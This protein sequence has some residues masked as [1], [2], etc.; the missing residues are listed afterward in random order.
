MELQI[1]DRTSKETVKGEVVFHEQVEEQPAIKSVT[2][3]VVQSKAEAR[4][5]AAKLIVNFLGSRKLGQGT[6]ALRCTNQPQQ[7]C[8][9]STAKYPQRLLQDMCTLVPKRYFPNT[10]GRGHPCPWSRRMI[11]RA[12]AEYAYY[13][14]PKL[15]GELVD[16]Q[17][18]TSVPI[19]IVSQDN[20]DQE[21]AQ[22]GAAAQA[23]AITNKFKGK[24][25][26][27]CL[28]PNAE[29]SVSMVFAGIETGS[30]WGYAALPPR[31]PALQYTLKVAPQ[32]ANAAALGIML[33]SYNF[34]RYKIPNTSD[35]K[36]PEPKAK[37]V[38]PLGADRMAVTTLASAFTW[39]R[40]LITTPAEDMGPGHLAAEAAAMA[41]AHGAICRVIEG[42]ELLVQKYPAIHTVGRASTRP[43][44]LI[45]IRWHPKDVANVEALPK[46][47]L[48]GKGVCFDT[49]G[50][51]IKSTAGMRN[52]KKDMGGGAIVL[53]L[54][55]VI[56][57][58]QLPVRLRVMVPAVENNIS[59]NSYRPLDVLKTRAGITV[60]VGTSSGTGNVGMITCLHAYRMMIHDALLHWIGVMCMPIQRNILVR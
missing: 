52:M 17:S 51:N 56:M 46:L 58:H 26:D 2:S 3:A 54:A 42:E 4:A 37:F 40:Q 31:L 8:L 24:N 12:T 1:V 39:A 60:E 23:W 22:H 45:D 36:A 29:G 20:V 6:R 44:R 10:A 11:S 18:T 48:V 38:W 15:Q 27:L 33:A 57:S 53:A 32:E 50:L 14:P 55:H 21:L 35:D 7:Y 49:G 47:A 5:H 13:F 30:P 25:G 16:N 9:N 34:D 19:T 28:I 43:P 41:A 59:G